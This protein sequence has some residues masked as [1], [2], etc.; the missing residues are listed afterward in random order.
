MKEDMINLNLR[1]IIHNNE[2]CEMYNFDL[3]DQFCL[4]LWI[5]EL[6]VAFDFGYELASYLILD[7]FDP[8][9]RFFCGVPM[10]CL[11]FSWFH[12]ILSL[13]YPLSKL[14]GIV[15]IFIFFAI[16]YFFKHLNR[17]KQLSFEIR[18]V[19]IQIIA[20]LAFICLLSYF[21][22]F[23]LMFNNTFCIGAA[24]G[25]LPFHLNIISS[26][27][28]GC[29]YRR[30]SLYEV[31]SSFISGT[32]LTYPY[33]VNFLSACLISTG[34]ASLRSSVRFPSL[35]FGVSLILGIYHLSY[36]FTQKVIPSVLSLVLFFFLGG[37]GWTQLFTTKMF[38]DPNYLKY[39]DFI[40]EWPEHRNEYWFQPITQVLLPQRASLFSMPL[41]YWTI[42]MLIIGVKKEKVRYFFCAA[43]YTGLMPLV[44]VHSYVAIAQWA[45]VYCFLTFP[46]KNRKQWKKFIMFWLVYGIV[47]NLFSFPQLIPYIS[48][49]K[50][51]KDHFIRIQPIFNN[52]NPF[53]MWWYGLGPFSAIACVFGWIALKKRQLVLYIPSFVVFLTTNIIRYQPW[54][55]DNLKLFY[56]AWIPIAV[57]V[58]STYLYELSALPK[59]YSF[60][61]ILF[62]SMVFSSL[63]SLSIGL[64]SVAPI[65]TPNDWKFGQW[66]SENTPT[67]SIF[68]ADSIHTQPI[69]TIAGRQLLLG[70]GG[71]VLSHGFDYY[72][73]DS[74]NQKIGTLENN[75]YLSRDHNISYI[76]TSKQYFPNFGQIADPFWLNIYN[77]STY[78]VWKRLFD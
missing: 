27:S 38:T 75:L 67:N 71:W 62:L 29:N 46:Y 36:E 11:F 44:Q 56:A 33:M 35:F 49:V 5:F 4:M 1:T 18:Y 70:Y 23:G 8:I 7:A 40:F 52:K 37:F 54:E 31:Y 2:A 15:S 6:A 78:Q 10:G 66:I 22:F 53:T 74:I 58:V 14:H 72:A 30:N 69:A 61:L 34:S 32:Q 28:I 45:I 59:C 16:S 20:I 47:A 63:L 77:D 55:M 25:D 13:F 21:L 3:D 26:F 57:P 17:K 50:E 19:K 65:F 42:L 60:A 48:R 43:I 68:A 51:A 12:F 64:V 41:C 9:I 76:V 24:Y 39:V 73:L